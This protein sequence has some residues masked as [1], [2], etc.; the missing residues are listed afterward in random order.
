MIERRLIPPQ[1]KNIIGEITM[2]IQNE[3][4]NIQELSIFLGTSE[5]QIRRKIKDENI[6]Y[7]RLDRNNG[8]YKF[9]RSEIQQ[10]LKDNAT[11]S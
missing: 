4:L 8:Q 7:V 2:Q 6:P 11:K 1:S 10:W 5:R 9:S 3:Y